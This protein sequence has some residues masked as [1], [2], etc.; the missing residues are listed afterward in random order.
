MDKLFAGID[1][2]RDTNAVFLMLPDGSKHS[3]FTVKNNLGGA[4]TLCQRIVCALS[5][6]KLPS[7]YNRH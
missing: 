7:A 5:E 1:V 2:S 4:Q 3:S 6:K